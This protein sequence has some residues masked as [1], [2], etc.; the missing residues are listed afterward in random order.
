VCVYLSVCVCSFVLCCAV[1]CVCV[2]VFLL[3]DSVTDLMKNRSPLLHRGT[4]CLE[5]Q[6][7]PKSENS[8]GN[9]STPVLKFMGQHKMQV[10]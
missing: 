3:T 10:M 1:C 8:T 5:G 9:E 6:K 4:P 2:C 7:K